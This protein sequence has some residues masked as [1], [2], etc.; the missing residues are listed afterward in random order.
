MTLLIG[1]NSILGRLPGIKDKRTAKKFFKRNRVQL[2][3]D[4]VSRRPMIYEKE[5]EILAQRLQKNNF[6]EV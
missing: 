2:V 3:Y 1:W 6:K 5:I 4:P